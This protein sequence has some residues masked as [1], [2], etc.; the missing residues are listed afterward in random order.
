MPFQTGT[1][2]DYVALLDQLI[3]FATNRSA[4]S[5][6]PSAGGTGYVVGDILTLSTG[7]FINGAATF[8][9]KTVSGGAVTAVV[10]REAGDYT[11]DPS[12]PSATTGG[13]GS[14]CTLTVTMADTGWTVERT[15]KEAASATVSA[16]GTGHVV[17]DLLTVVGGTKST[18]AVFRVETLSGS[19]VATVSLW[20]RGNYDLTPA[21][22]ATTTSN[23]SGT[24][25]TLTV[26]YADVFL[27]PN[28]GAIS[29]TIANGGTGYTV[30]DVLTLSGG[31]QTVTAQFK[32]LTVSSGA[33]TSVAAT[34]KGNY[35][36]R[37]SNPV[38]TTGGTGTGATLT[39]T[40]ENL[41]PDPNKNYILVGEGSGDDEI[42]VGV[43]CFDQGGGATNWE[44]AGF[45]GYNAA[46][47]FVN[48]AGISPGRH[49][50]GTTAEQRGAYV[51]LTT[52]ATISY[53]WFVDGRRLCG[54]MKIGTTYLNFF[55]GWTNPFG[56]ES[57]FPYPLFIEG[58]TSDRAQL[59]T[60]SSRDIS[61]LTDPIAV[62]TGNGPGF[63]RD[64]AGAWK[65]VQNSVAGTTQLGSVFVYPV[66][67][68]TAA[69]LAT[70]SAADIIVSTQQF[71]PQDYAPGTSAA[72]SLKIHDSPGSAVVLWP[73]IIIEASPS[74]MLHG[75]IPEVAWVS[76]AG[77]GLVAEDAILVGD[78]TWRV[79]QNGNQT[80]DHKKFAIRE[81]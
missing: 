7:T 44:L 53:W 75:E 34:R 5:A 20:V 2:T 58:C 47:S 24:G 70:K 46:L 17:G 48:Q 50:G 31:T 49:D 29:A 63:I 76:G 28:E 57:E 78:D 65:S 60:E 8:R 9:V 59:Y 23:A 15:S 39:V 66:A 14:G 35:T 61:G 37:P 64:P 25:C 30:N 12:S 16:G 72:V 36:V 38:S 4:V 79:F 13:T 22:P 56:T 71:S 55:M 68:P 41:Q 10:L 42:R 1:A 21:N 81:A 32:V 62:A 33:V 51:P 26:T 27:I 69:V 74:E 52:T 3:D 73:T 6:T 11:A 43:R 80:E 19:A 45:T 54:V 67:N 18:A 77:A 40:W